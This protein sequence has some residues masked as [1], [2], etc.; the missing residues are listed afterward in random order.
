MVYPPVLHKFRVKVRSSEIISVV[1]LDDL[2]MVKFGGGGGISGTNVTPCRM[3]IQAWPLA[4]AVVE[5]DHAPIRE[6]VPIS[7]MVFPHMVPV[8]ATAFPHVEWSA[9][10]E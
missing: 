10:D 8:T 3:N 9:Y 1:L 7:Y 6:P 2:V 4:E 5:Y